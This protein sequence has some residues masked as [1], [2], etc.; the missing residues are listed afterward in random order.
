MTQFA[1]T[2]KVHTQIGWR[3]CCTKHAGVITSAMRTAGHPTITTPA[4]VGSECADCYGDHGVVL[5]TVSPASPTR[6]PPLCSHPPGGA[7]S[8]IQ[9]AKA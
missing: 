7:G 2:L 1:A 4:P 3:Y 9:G 6:E 8:F 5:D